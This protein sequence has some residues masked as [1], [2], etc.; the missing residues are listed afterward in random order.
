M[1]IFTK[2]TTW[3][4]KHTLLHKGQTIIVGLSGGPDSI[5]LLYYLLSRKQE[6]NLTLISAHLNHEWRPCASQDEAFCR[7]LCAKLG[8]TYVSSTLSQLACHIKP[9]GSKEQD[10]R[11]ARRFFFQ[12]LAQKYNAHAVALAHHKDDQEETFFIRLLRGA[13]ITGLSCM[14]PRH[15]IYIRPLLCVTK[16]EI[17]SW[18]AQHNI[19]YVIDPTNANPDYLRN[20]IRNELMPLLATIDDRSHINISKSID[21]LQQTELFLQKLTTQTFATI[22]EYDTSKQ[23]YIITLP[24]LFAQ[25]IFMQYRL[26]IHWLTL[27]KVALPASTN[28]LDEIVRFLHQPENKSHKMH[29]TWSIVKKKQQCYVLRTSN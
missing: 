29:G 28:F 23:C 8:V 14:W 7:A 27:E 21:H 3:A 5:F 10:A 12:Q 26:L 13:T 19:T 9:S 25:D 11:N 20:R 4:D 16:Q 24:T 15:D 22:A 1:N 17:L 2:I 6:L 18:L